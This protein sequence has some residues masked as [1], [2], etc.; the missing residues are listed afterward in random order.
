M[1]KSISD[2][3]NILYNVNY[4]YQVEREHIQQCM[5][6]QY[7]DSECPLFFR[8]GRISVNLIRGLFSR[9]PLYSPTEP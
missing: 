3:L 4:Y 6:L 7:T 2:Y 5:C 9:L 1:I 8:R